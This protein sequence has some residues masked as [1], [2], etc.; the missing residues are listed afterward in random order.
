MG[1]VVLGII[2]RI[3]N[4][5]AVGHRNWF[6][7]FDDLV[8]VRMVRFIRVLAADASAHQL[9]GRP[10]RER[11]FKGDVLNYP[12]GLSRKITLQRRGWDGFV[13]PPLLDTPII[14]LPTPRTFFLHRASSP[15]FP[16][17]ILQTA[18]PKMT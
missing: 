2:Y 9:N 7:T 12:A 18:S 15:C 4:T 13:R 6:A 1:A 11:Q 16:K 8:G 14:F 3:S 10:D 17:K 5:S